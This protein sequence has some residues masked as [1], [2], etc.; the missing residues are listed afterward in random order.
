MSVNLPAID[1]LSLDDAFSENVY[2]PFHECWT[3]R[4]D[5]EL[6]V[7]DDDEQRVSR[8]SDNDEERP[9]ALVIVNDKNRQIVLLSVDNKLIK[10]HV[11]GIA[12]CAIFDENQFH[13]VEFKTNAFSHW[14][15]SIRE[16][17]EKAISQLVETICFFRNRLAPLN[18]NLEEFVSLYCH[19]VISDSFPR[20]R[21]IEQEYQLR[22]ADENEGI[23][24]SINRKLFWEKLML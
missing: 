20:M 16:T 21:A 14:E 17:F 15:Q 3:V 7:V 10:D 12:D 24:L 13:F 1:H 11:G 5:S 23:G 8:F 4:M 2:R 9:K 18:I 19:I 6:L 22:F